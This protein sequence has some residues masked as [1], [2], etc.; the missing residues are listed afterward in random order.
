MQTTYISISQDIT[1][2]YKTK[3]IDFYSI[4]KYTNRYNYS[5][6]LFKD[7]YRNK[8]NTYAISN[9]LCFDIDEGLSIQECKELLTNWSYMI[10]TTKSHQK[11]K[12]GVVCDRYRLILPLTEEPSMSDY[13]EF[14]D[15]VGQMLGLT[16]D[17]ATKDVSR[18][19]FPNKDQKVYINRINRETPLDTNLLRKM[20]LAD[21]ARKLEES[22]NKE[23]K[24]TFEGNVDALV[25]WF[26]EHTV[27]GGR[28]NFLFRMT[29]A[30]EKENIPPNDIV[31]MV[32]EVNYSLDSPL[33]D[34]ELQKTVLREYSI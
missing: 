8:E 32:E 16:H 4:D 26:K 28:N 18:F 14:Y 19:Y 30:L 23:V 13:G 21:K 9:V 10:I 29:K 15:Y 22:K 2:N 27:E 5:F 20:F 6:G 12:H 25:R 17:R 31:R 24:I 7:G 33:S 34:K 3:G 1:E 11:D